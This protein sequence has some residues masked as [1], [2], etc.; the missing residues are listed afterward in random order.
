MLLQG[1]AVEYGDFQVAVL[2]NRFDHK[3]Q[4]NDII[5]SNMPFNV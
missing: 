1:A 3:I 4:K 2:A 5:S